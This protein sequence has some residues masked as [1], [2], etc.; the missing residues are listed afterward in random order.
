MKSEVVW[1]E[2]LSLLKTFLSARVNNQQD[3]ADILQQVML[4][5]HNNLSSLREHKSV[6][7]W[8]F[9]IA[10]RSIIDFYRQQSRN[11]NLDGNS[12]WYFDDRKDQHALL[13]CLQPFI[14]QL[15]KQ[16]AEL[17]L[18][19]ELN[20]MSQ[21]EYAELVGVSY[22]TLKSRVQKSRLEL[23]KLFEQCCEYERD[24]DGNV[25]GVKEIKVSNK[26]CSPCKFTAD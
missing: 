20:G 1:S 14:A 9:Q 5:A 22:S 4:K 16:Q 11:A 6:Q 15:P 2:Y 25:L 23:K 19:I 10:N 8:L 3:V 7:S 12:L 13:N 18:D 17:L 21:K 26:N 24:A